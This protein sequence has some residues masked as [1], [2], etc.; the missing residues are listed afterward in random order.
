MKFQQLFD[1]GV[2]LRLVPF[3]LTD[4][5]EKWFSSLPSE[6]IKTWDEFKQIF[7]KKI[8]PPIKQQKSEMKL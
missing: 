6:S 1:D 2:R 4:Y 5:A 3:A 7:L 8:S